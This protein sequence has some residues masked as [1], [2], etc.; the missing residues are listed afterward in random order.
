MKS[1]SLGK[2]GSV[3]W[4][5][6]Q[7][8]GQSKPFPSPGVAAAPAPGK[9][10]VSSLPSGLRLKAEGIDFEVPSGGVVRV[11]RR[12]GSELKLQDS[13]VSRSHAVMQM[14]EGRLWVQD[15]GSTNGTFLNDKK[16]EPQ[17]WHPV[18]PGSK[19]KLGKVILSLTQDLPGPQVPPGTEVLARQGLQAAGQVA[20]GGLPVG[21]GLVLKELG[22]EGRFHRLPGEGELTV[23]RQSGNDLVLSDG[24]VSRNH[25]TFQQR[26]GTISVVDNG[27]RNGLEVNG[28]K[29]PSGAQQSLAAGDLLQLG[30]TRFRLVDTN[31]LDFESKGDIEKVLDFRELVT[32]P[33]RQQEKFGQVVPAQP[34]AYWQNNVEARQV[35]ENYLDRA[36]FSDAEAFETMVKESHRLAVEGSEGDHR[37]YKI[38]DRVAD[39]EQLPAGE[40]HNGVTGGIRNEES[41]TVEE[42]ARAYGDPYRLDQ[43][44]PVK[45]VA[46]E[47]IS[48]AD[49]P[50]NFPLMGGQRHIYPSPRAFG[51]YFEQMRKRLDRLDKLPAESKQEKLKLIGEFYQYGANV[52]P[53]RNVNNSL[54]MNFTNVLLKR[55]GFKPVYHGILDHAAHRLQPRAF[56]AYFQDW[57][58]D[59]GRIS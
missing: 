22:R 18:V 24:T 51:D 17:E 6:A 37:Y 16:L 52:R 40:F 50:Q 55:H 57:V 35:F 4:Q 3:Y 53:F 47:G 27:S 36:D 1:P 20:Q 48:E 2:L 21:I 46:L 13:D 9:D 26:N 33:T 58:K 41:R 25:A 43:E 7:Q 34:N 44:N 45:A 14:H 59:Q 49:Q 54:F 29:L 12:E 56:N 39:S 28:N 42:I 30:N 5:R 31:P 8:S 11:G 19:V 32:D 10:S 23:G 15:S 38:R